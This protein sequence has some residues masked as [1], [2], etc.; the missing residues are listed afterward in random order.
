MCCSSLR[1][2]P[3]MNEGLRTEGVTCFKSRS[4]QWQ[5][6]CC[7]HWD[8]AHG[9]NDA[10]SIYEHRASPFCSAPCSL[11]SGCRDVSFSMQKGFLLEYLRI[12]SA[13]GTMSRQVF[14]LF[15]FCLLN[16]IKALCYASCSFT[17]RRLK[18]GGSVEAQAV[19]W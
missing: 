18:R 4:S 16:S 6:L 3:H 1:F 12:F 11:L 5:Q 15:G 13:H 2:L 19:D 17:A 10:I 7:L 14:S 8:V 9:E